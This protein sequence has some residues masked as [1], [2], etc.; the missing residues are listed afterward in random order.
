MRSN[1]IHVFLL[2]FLARAS[3]SILWFF[4]VIFFVISSVSLFAVPFRYTQNIMILTH[5]LFILRTFN[6]TIF[7]FGFLGTFSS[8]VIKMRTKWKNFRFRCKNILLNDGPF[9]FSC[10]FVIRIEDYYLKWL[11]KCLFWAG[12]WWMWFMRHIGISKST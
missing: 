4:R 9:F 6:L 8:I 11:R 1:F 5:I 7:L 10:L 2:F 3:R 12:S